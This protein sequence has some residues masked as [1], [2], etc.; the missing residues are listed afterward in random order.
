MTVTIQLQ[1]EVSMN[2]GGVFHPCTQLWAV[3]TGPATA[4]LAYAWDLDGDGVKDDS[5][6]EVPVLQLPPDTTRFAG[7]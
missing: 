1:I 4:H 5:T 3:V 2:A 7:L 6:A